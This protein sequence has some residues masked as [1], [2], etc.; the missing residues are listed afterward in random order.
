MANEAFFVDGGSYVAEEFRRLLKTF[1]YSSDPLG[2]IISG[3]AVVQGAGSS[4]K[5]QVGAAFVNESGGGAY[6]GATQA[7]S[8]A[9]TISPAGGTPRTDRVYAIILDPGAGATAGEMGFGIS[10][11]STSIPSLAIPLADVTANVNGT[12]TI[13]DKRVQVQ[14]GEGHSTDTGWVPLTL[15]NGWIAFP[16]P[17]SAGIPANPAIGLLLRRRGKVVQMIGNVYESGAWTG[18][19]SNPADIPAT[20]PAWATPLYG[21]GWA[22]PTNNTSVPGGFQP[23]AH[24][25]IYGT[26]DHGSGMPAGSVQILMPD[27]PNG[28]DGAWISATWLV[29]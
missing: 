25:R 6:I 1:Y 5:V 21:Q 29:E 15:T 7:D 28:A 17:A 20:L 24:L 18:R 19:R 4:V 23:T 12:L 27:D 16:F 9:L 11:G 22:V 8:A 3:L 26:G 10:S 2:G 13:V 14:S